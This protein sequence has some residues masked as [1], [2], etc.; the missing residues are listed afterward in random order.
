MSLLHPG[1]P[2][3]CCLLVCWPKALFK[4]LYLFTGASR[5]LAAV[6]LGCLRLEESGH[7]TPVCFPWELLS[8]R[9]QAIFP[10]DL[11]LL[12]LP[13][14]P[15]SLRLPLAL[16]C[17]QLSVVTPALH[18]LPNEQVLTENGYSFTTAFLYLVEASTVSLEC[19][20]EL[21]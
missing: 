9:T 5:P 1:G 19:I 13:H 12:G 4:P 15:V 16:W 11:V 8:P 6:A 10:V 20:H 18:S 14:C 17:L 3:L 7:S 21:T 2:Q